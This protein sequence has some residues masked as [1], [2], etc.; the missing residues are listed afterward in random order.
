MKS[1]ITPTEHEKAEWSR[2]AVDAY[3]TGRN[4][5]GHRFSM[6]ATLCKGEPCDVHWFDSLQND[7]RAWLCDGFETRGHVFYSQVFDSQ[8]EYDV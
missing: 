3:R 5:I 4:S 1:I 8:D 7:Y 2:M 6:A